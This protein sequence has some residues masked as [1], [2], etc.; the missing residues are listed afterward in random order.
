MNPLLYFGALFGVLLALTIGLIFTA[1]ATKWKPKPIKLIWVSLT[2][3]V[4][5]LLAGTVCSISG[6]D[7]RILYWW[8]LGLLAVLVLFP[9]I[10]IL[11]G[12][13]QRLL[14]AA[15]AFLCTHRTKK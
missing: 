13:L 7:I 15:L 2:V 5:V 6:R 3:L 1:R 8:L 12:V 4:A 10:L 11:G 14:F 9:P